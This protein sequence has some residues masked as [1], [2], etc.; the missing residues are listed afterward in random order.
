MNPAG[1]DADR[2][3]VVVGAE[4]EDDADDHLGR[5]VRILAGRRATDPRRSLCVLVDHA[6]EHL[7]APDVHADR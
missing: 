3:D 1:A 6:A 5:V 4:L 7:R 2:D